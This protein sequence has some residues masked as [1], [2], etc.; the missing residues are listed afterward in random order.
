MLTNEKVI[1][2]NISSL[3]HSII[4]KNGKLNLSRK[5][6][7]ILEEDRRLLK[8]QEE[9]LSILNEIG[10]ETYTRLYPYR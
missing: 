1:R 5:E 6:K 3:E 4:L 10:E 2:A 8:E 9:R 7:R